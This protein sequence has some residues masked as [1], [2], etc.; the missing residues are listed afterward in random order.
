MECIERKRE[1]CENW[2]LLL[3]CILPLVDSLNGYFVRIEAISIGSIYKIALICVLGVMLKG[4][5]SSRYWKIAISIVL[6]MGLSII[7]NVVCLNGGILDIDYPVKLLFN[8]LLFLLLMQLYDNGVLKG[9][10]FFKI[11]DFNSY[12]V[13]FVILIPYLLGM[14]YKVYSGDV[15]YVGFYYARNELS[16]VLIIL[17]YFCI[18]KLLQQI[19]V[20]TLL[21]TIGV[22]LCAILLNTKACIF[23]CGFG[24]VYWLGFWV[25]KKPMKYKISAIVILLAGGLILGGF[26]KEQIIKSLTRHMHL[27]ELYDNAIFST[28]LSGRDAFLKELWSDLINSGHFILRFLL[29]NGFCSNDLVEMDFFDI[30]FFLGVAGVTMIVILLLNIFLRGYRNIKGDG[31]NFRILAYLVIIGLMFLA[32]HVLFMA[33]SG[34][35]FVLFCLFIMTYSRKGLGDELVNTPETYK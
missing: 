27:Y 6:L 22:L 29:G 19:K 13:I 16:V 28:F 23:A 15:G 8:V 9:E 18:Y 14:G 4:K 10:S 7:I 1:K 12:G 20:G 33:V 17:L 24:I 26:W 3:F 11:L 2:I 25:I 34:T 32:G 21:Q 31:N 5:L 35:Y 30:F